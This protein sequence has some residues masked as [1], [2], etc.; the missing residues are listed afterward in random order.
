MH[1]T[2]H[3]KDLKI[4]LS[5]FS[6]HW[7]RPST[8]KFELNLCKIDPVIGAIAIFVSAILHQV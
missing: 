3:L 8:N 4:F 2:L 1:V 7:E 5:Q 6:L